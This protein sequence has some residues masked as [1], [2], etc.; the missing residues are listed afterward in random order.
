MLQLQNLQNNVGLLTQHPDSRIL[1]QSSKGWIVLHS[2]NISTRI[3]CEIATDR[4]LDKEFHL[5]DEQIQHFTTYNYTTRREGSSRGK[6]LT[7]HEKN[8][9][10]FCEEMLKIA[11]CYDSDMENWTVVFTPGCRHNLKNT[12]IT[13]QMRVL[14]KKRDYASRVELY[15]QLLNAELLLYV[16]ND[17]PK[18]YGTIG[19]FNSYALF[20]EDKYYY[21]YD[22]RGVD[23]VRKY[24][25]EIFYEL[26][27][28]KAGSVWINPKGQVGGELYQNEIEMLA[29]AM[30][31]R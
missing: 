18:V 27:Q 10:D 1:L 2:F 26:H 5:T 30:Y 22:P 12:K 19:K 21:H 25:H 13:S 8:I 16:D 29:K 14:S 17:S 7:L 11:T 23:V 6:L 3:L 20:T 28:L 9:S 31:R 4:H 15:Q 24:G